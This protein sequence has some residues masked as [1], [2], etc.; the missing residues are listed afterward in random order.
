MLIG[1]WFVTR[2]SDGKQG[3]APGGF[4]QPAL[5]AR[6]GNADRATHSGIYAN[7]SWNEI[8]NL[9]RS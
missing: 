2:V 7:A 6:I 1:W 3:Y 4:L 8:I 5:P 9:F